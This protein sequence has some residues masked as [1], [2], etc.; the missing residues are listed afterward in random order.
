[1][2]LKFKITNWLVKLRQKT[3]NI[4]ILQI[5]VPPLIKSNIWPSHKCKKP[6]YTHTHILYEL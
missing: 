4:I 5:I 6:F 2:F 1:M 3:K